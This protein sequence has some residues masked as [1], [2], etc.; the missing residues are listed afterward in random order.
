[1]LFGLASGAISILSDGLHSITDS[2]SNV[3]AL[4]GVRLASRPPDADHPYGHRKFETMASVGILLFLLV[5]LVQ[6][7]WRPSTGC[8]TAAPPRSRWPASA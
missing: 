4:V 7:L 3:V 6:V 2:A 8:A 5:A 1:M